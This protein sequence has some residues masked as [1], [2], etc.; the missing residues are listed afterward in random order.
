MFCFR[1]TWYTAQAPPHRDAATH[2]STTT[3]LSP[4]PPNPPHHMST[5]TSTST[6]TTPSN[7]KLPHH[8]VFRLDARTSDPAAPRSPL[9]LHYP[10]RQRRGNN[11]GGRRRRLSL[12]GLRRRLP[13]YRGQGALQLQQGGRGGAPR[14]RGGYGKRGTLPDLRGEGLSLHCRSRALSLRQGQVKEGKRKDIHTSKRKGGGAAP[15]VKKHRQRRM[16]RP[17]QQH[18]HH[19]STSPKAKAIQSTQQHTIRMARPTQQHNHHSSTPHHQK[20]KQSKA[21]KRRYTITAHG[22]FTFG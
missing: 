17:A 10:S 11:H 1:C 4:A 15:R 14:L 3:A 6:S 5:G 16:G 2:N 7:P 18:K 20:Q 21:Y 8:H 12:P 13:L 19:S 9:R 22:P